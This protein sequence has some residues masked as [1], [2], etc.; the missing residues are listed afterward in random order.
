MIALCLSREC[1][2]IKNNME[3][4]P[5]ALSSSLSLGPRVSISLALV[6]SLPKR[7]NIH[8]KTGVDGDTYLDEKLQIG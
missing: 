2:Y 5:P 1:W 4:K 7:G 8:I 6:I 3:L